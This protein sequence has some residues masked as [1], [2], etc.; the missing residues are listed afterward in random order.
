MKTERKEKKPPKPASIYRKPI[1]EKAFKKHY[2]GGL[3]QEKDRAFLSS[4][5]EMLDGRYTLKTGLDRPTLMRLNVLAKAIKGN[6]GFLKT[7]PAVLALLLT[8][9]VA[10]FV[11]FFMNPVLE[12]SVERGLETA[13]GGR[14]DV[15]RFRLSLARLSVSMA[16]VSVADRDE[17]M[18]NLFETGR[19]ELSL[20]PSALFRGRV[21]IEEASA[22]SIALGTPRK[23][24]GALE[25]AEAAP[26]AQAKPSAGP[27]LTSVSSLVDLENFDAGALLER[28]KDK[29]RAAAAYAEAEAA[30]GAAADRWESRV[31][32]SKKAV[33]ELGAL[34]K[35]VVSLKAKDFRTVEDAQAAL[36]N[37]RKVA[38]VAATTARDAASVAGELKAEAAAA[39]DLA[40][41]ART[42]L[43]DDL[44]YLK[45]LVNPK[46]GVARGILEPV[47]WAILDDKVDRYVYY[48]RRGLEAAEKLK[49][50]AAASEMKDAK[51]KVAAA[52]RGRDV[53]FPSTDYPRFRLGLLASNFAAGD[54]NWKVELREVSSEPDL[55]PSPTTLRLEMARGGI[56]ADADIVADLRSGSAEAFS[57]NLQGTRLPLDLGN[58]LSV[59]GLGG[60]TGRAAAK[61][62][63]RG[64]KSGDVAASAEVAVAEAAAAAPSGAFG[65]S[66]ADAQA[67]VDAV[68]LDID[69]SKKEGEDA[70]F[71][72]ESNLDSLV[73]KAAA[74]LAKAYA[75]KATAAVEQAL[76]EYVEAELAGKLSSERID[77]L[78][79]LAEGD[80]SAAASLKKEVDAKKA[81]LEGRAQAILNQGKQA[82][83]AAA[84]KAKQEADAAA[85]AAEAA[86]RKAAD[87]AKK[88]AAA[89][90]AEALKKLE[91]PKL[92]F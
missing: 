87:D 31:S 84:A 30:Y 14:A 48:G 66:M 9:A 46:S 83:E 7:G 90:A 62:D 3:E 20:N 69:Y 58:A 1:A 50:T 6:R 41:R 38:D 34:S 85:Q 10:V 73:A 81:E 33:A 15:A 63:L 32:D 61:V 60:F 25:G 40:R 70:D 47:V 18:R 4:S 2:I 49:A 67:S 79:A 72:V 75:G 42:A 59:I 22:A 65:K 16:A 26:Q 57:V 91:K 36:E 21:Y 71:S 27:S 29:L 51:R 24:S 74:D 44:D 53:V 64:R 35:S 82:A 8:A 92:K 55:V 11:L 12:R 80:A 89:E 28:E 76:R 68:E 43:A 5:F 19:I 86:A 54:Q 13:F 77:S 88:K 39:A 45:S 56:G 78:V 52:S 37:A 17:P 23:T